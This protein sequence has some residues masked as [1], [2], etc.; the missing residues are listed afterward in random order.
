MAQNIHF[1][2]KVQQIVA[3][4]LL[5]CCTFSCK[6]STVAK[7]ISEGEVNEVNIIIS[8]VLWNGAVGDSLRKKFAAPVEGLTQEE[9]LFT[10]NQ[11]HGQAFDADIK[12]GRN[13]IFVEKTETDN[14]QNYNYR[15]NDYCTPQNIFTLTGRNTAQLQ[16]AIR[17]YSDEIIKTIR[18]GE[19]TVNQRRNEKLGLRDT[20]FFAKAYGISM[21][22]PVTYRYALKNDNFIWLKKEISGGNTNL[23]LYR[24]PYIALE[25]DKDMVNN[26]IKMRDSIGNMYVHGQET[27]TYM[28]TETAYSPSMFMTSFTDK[29][30]FET[31]GNWEMKNDFM[32][33]PFI[34]YSI[35][36]DKN[37]CYLVIEG[38][39][40]SPSSPKRDLILELESIIR[41]VKFL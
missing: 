2:K 39:I 10:L 8:D 4:C 33:G 19:I 13:I 29:R 27:G 37:K 40:Y 14:K 41:S 25:K 35:R 11:Y 36:D 32:N 5:V 23:L 26:I 31:R 12:K 34:N 15:Q 21:K 1:M 6:K 30:A 3:L 18:Q 16:D 24:V 22:V 28:V 17:I 38:F 9:P 7:A 20:T